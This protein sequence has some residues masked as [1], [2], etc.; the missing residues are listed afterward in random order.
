[1]NALPDP[2]DL[3]APEP[4]LPLPPAGAAPIAPLAPASLARL[5]THRRPLLLQ[6]PMGPFFHHLAH[7]LRLHGQTVWKVNFNGGDDLY[8][9]GDEVIRFDQPIDAWP[10]RLRAVV[11]ELRIDAIVL[12]G[13]SRR[14]HQLAMEEAAL[15]QVPVY[16]FEEG[17]VR[18]DYVTL[19][20]D[21]VNGLSA[22]PRQA[23]F[24]RLLPDEPPPP[25]PLPTHQRFKRVAGIAMTYALAIAWGRRRYPH[26]THHRSL[27]PFVEGLRWVRGGQR[28]WVAHFR[29]RHLLPMLTS[30]AH[31]GRWYL[32]PLQVHNDSQIL[33]HSPFRTLREFI[34]TVVASFAAHAPPDTG[35]VFKHH[36]LDR[37]Y[38][39]YAT[40][41]AA[42]AR[43]HGV[44][45]RVHYL[46]D[47]HLPTLLKH[48]RGVVTINSTTGLQSLYHGT[49]V[50]TLG[51]CFY[52]VDGLVHPGPL[53]T[54]WGEPGT[55]DDAL[56]QRFRHHVVRQT[57]LNASFYGESPGLLPPDDGR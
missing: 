32:A 31:S 5:L 7:T 27:H 6:G 17:Y 20:R 25:A 57:Q 16:V 24:Y 55:V 13:Q 21:G 53:E 29:E 26:Y 22:I 40:H 54:F 30:A 39:D 15:L 11:R 8:Y 36:P 14:M 56:Y 23:A 28:K 34:D 48:A 12:F 37:P 2:V 42:A 43:T 19:E 9:P 33:H 47:Q 44:F 41:I 50:I 49:P 45:G 46:H 35:L 3:L 51:D 4:L 52:A 38:H 18:P 10:A 1:M